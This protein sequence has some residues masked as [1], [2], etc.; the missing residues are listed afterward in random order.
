MSIRNFLLPVGLALTSLALIL[1]FAKEGKTQTPDAKISEPTLQSQCRDLKWSD[2]ANQTVDA[3]CNRVARSLMKGIL[4][5]GTASLLYGD[6]AKAAQE[7]HAN[8]FWL[9]AR[10][11]SDRFHGTRNETYGL[12]ETEVNECLVQFD[13]MPYPPLPAGDTFRQLNAPNG[14]LQDGWDWYLPS[15]RLIDFNKFV[16]ECAAN[17]SQGPLNRVGRYKECSQIA[18]E[19]FGIKLMYFTNPKTGEKF[20]SPNV[21]LK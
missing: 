19:R 20:V 18:M 12:S 1:S 13:F 11:A 9:C 17:D 7:G 8:A 10:S 3:I 21:L 4:L 14:A 15:S 5:K 16:E 2:S 6:N